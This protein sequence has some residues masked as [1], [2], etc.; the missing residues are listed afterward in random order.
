MSCNEYPEDY[1]HMFFED[2][3]QETYVESEIKG[4]LRT[5]VFLETNIIDMYFPFKLTGSNKEVLYEGCL[6]DLYKSK[7]Y[8]KLMKG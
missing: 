1:Y 8:K 7:F 5:L 4:I 2:Q 3:E 6:S